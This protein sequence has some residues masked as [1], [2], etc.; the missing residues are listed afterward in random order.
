MKRKKITTGPIIATPPVQRL[1]PGSKSMVRLTST[2]DI[3]RLPQDRESL[4]LQSSGNS[5]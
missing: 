3:S 1:E 4:L 5:P 2:P